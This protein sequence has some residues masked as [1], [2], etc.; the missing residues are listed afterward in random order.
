M[1]RDPEGRTLLANLNLDGFAPGN[2]E[3]FDSIR[4][5]WRVVQP[6]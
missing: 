4:A 2:E 3:L 1:T 6:A 5:M